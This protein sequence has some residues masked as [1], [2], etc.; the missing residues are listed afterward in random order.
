VFEIV[1]P[2]G[3]GVAFSVMRCFPTRERSDSMPIFAFES[4]RPAIATTAY[5]SPTAVVI[6]D[7]T[8]GQRCYIGHGAI[9]RGDYGAIEIGDETAVEEG[10]IVH[11]RPGNRT[12]IE[13][14]VTLGHGAMIH[15]AVVRDGAVIGMR[16]VVSDDAEVGAGAIV[17]ELGLVRSGQVV[18]PRK[19]AVGVPVR[20]I[21]DVGD[22]HANMTRRAKEIY[23]DL[24]ERYLAGGMVEVER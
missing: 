10:V 14:R 17:G 21:G 18:P 11:A 20:V 7:V 12:R 13:N 19:V 1:E 22:R 23:V 5:V 24:A 4:K 16:A 2:G 8:V 6:G 3:I 15:N 9:L